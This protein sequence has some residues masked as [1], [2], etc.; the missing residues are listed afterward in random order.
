MIAVDTNIVV[1]YLTK[2]HPKQSMRARALVSEN[3]VLLSRTVIL[4]CEWVLR[5]VYGYSPR[6]ICGALRAFAGLS[7][8][9][10][11]DPVVVAQAL[12]LAEKGVDFADALHLA[13]AEDCEVFATFDQDFIRRA[14]HAGLDKVNMP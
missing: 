5:S 6:E 1:R 14:K 2:D 13:A 8:V 10:T 4:E 11:E 3:D 12:D 7:T 9:S